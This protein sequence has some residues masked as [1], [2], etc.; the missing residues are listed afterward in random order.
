MIPLGGN[1]L[2]ERMRFGLGW[3]LAY[4]WDGRKVILSHRG[5]VWQ[6]G[7]WTIPIPLEW[8]IGKGY[9]EE[10]AIS[11]ERFCMWTHTLH[12]WFG[13]MFRYEGEFCII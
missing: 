12:P 8:L 13:E 5:Y 7:T 9:A 1:L 3:K 2:I 10:E 6:I 4:D 11:D